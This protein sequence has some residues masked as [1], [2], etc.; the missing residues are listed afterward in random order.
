MMVKLCTVCVFSNYLLLELP[1]D[2]E[3]DSQYF[4]SGLS[5]HLL[6]SAMNFYASDLVIIIFKI[7]LF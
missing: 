1:G 6:S 3:E 7:F 5:V 4:G 2:T